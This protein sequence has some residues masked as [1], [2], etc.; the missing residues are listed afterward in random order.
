M[1]LT[2][3][4]LV[5]MVLILLNVAFITLMERKILGLIQ[6]RKGPNKVSI[7]GILQPIADAAKLFLKE[8]VLPLSRNY[9]IFLISPIISITLAIILWFIYPIISCFNGLTLSG[10]LLLVILG[11]GT[12]PLFLTGWSSNRKYGMIGSLRGI[13]Q[14]IS[15]DIRLALILIS[16][17]LLRS[18][19]TI[20]DISFLVKA[21][22]GLLIIPFLFFFWLLSCVAETNRTP[23]DFSEGE[24]ELVSGFNIEYGGVGFTLI[25]MA[26]YS[27][28]LFFSAI[29]SSFF[30]VPFDYKLIISLRLVVLG[31]FWIWLRATYPRYRY[32]KL[33][34]IAWKILL[35][36]SLC[37]ICWLVAF[38]SM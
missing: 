30:I 34:N 23:F 12:Y 17:L 26:E 36:V 3:Y 19:I 13:A 9:I 31:F 37:L 11:L 20:I 10:V 14:T 18:C 24:S 2:F 16:I 32:D 8:F 6:Y 4:H 38:S 29:S 35:P 15:Y 27:I 25:F 33:I 22:L 7:Y 28:I 5:L 21:G 1:Y